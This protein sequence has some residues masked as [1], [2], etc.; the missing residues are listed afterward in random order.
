VGIFGVS[1]ILYGA[2]FLALRS[3]FAS[4][5]V[6]SAV[7][8]NSSDIAEVGARFFYDLILLPASLITRLFD[9]TLVAGLVAFIA[10]AVAG[11]LWDRRGWLHRFRRSPASG[12]VG[13]ASKLYFKSPAFFLSISLALTYILLKT[14][15]AAIN[16]NLNQRPLSEQDRSNAYDTA[17]LELALALLVAWLLYR[18]AWPAARRT[19]RAMILAQWLLVVASLTTLPMAYGRLRLPNDY[20][21]FSYAGASCEVRLLIG[22]TSNTWIVW[23]GDSRQTEVIPKEKVGSVFIGARQPLRHSDSEESKSRKMPGQ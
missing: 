22:E 9:S 18:I 1:G 10:V 3:H 2:G 20:P 23:N 17:V 5:E 19:E 13:V 4:L 12:R 21:V 7:P 11:F 15:W 8:A 14:G 16:I 6:W